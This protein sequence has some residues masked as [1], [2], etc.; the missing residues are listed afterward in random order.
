MSHCFYIVFVCPATSKL[1]C[2]CFNEIFPFGK[3]TNL[4]FKHL[5]LTNFR[6][7]SVHNQI[8]IDLN[9]HFST[10]AIC[11][12]KSVQPQ[13]GRTVKLEQPLS[14]VQ[15]SEELDLFSL[16]Q[17]CNIKKA[18]NSKSNSLSSLPAT[19]LITASVKKFVFTRC[20][21]W[22]SRMLTLFIRSAGGFLSI[23][24]HHIVLNY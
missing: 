4:D 13:I 10:S 18:S 11:K 17:M 20:R 19:K 24:N 9:L 22:L 21:V 23:L 3:Q 6:S 5:L 14:C 1:H 2:N 7:T 16:S 8:L 12:Q 15:P